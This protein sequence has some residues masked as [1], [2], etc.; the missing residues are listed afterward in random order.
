M[1]LPERQPEDL[2]QEVFL[3]YKEGDKH[4]KILRV[5]PER[6]IFLIGSSR[7]ADLRIGGEGIQGCHAALRFRKPYWYIC[8]LTGTDSLKING[9]AVVEAR[10]DEKAAVEI[11]EH[12]IELFSKERDTEL[13]KD[14]VNAEGRALHQVVIRL[15]GRVVETK[16]LKANESFEYDDGENLTVLPPPRDGKW[17][18]NEIGRRVVQQR[19]VG[20]QEILTNEALRLDQDL[21]KPFILSLVVFLFMFSALF[22]LSMGSQEAPPEVALDKKS[23]DIIFNAKAVK[24]KRVEAQKV[25]KTAKARAGGTSEQAQAAPGS[26]SMPE[27][28]MAPTTTGKPSVAL[29]SLRKA[30]LSNLVG[31]I[32]KRANK[33]GVLVAAQGVSADTPNAGRAFYST[34]TTTT[35]GGGSA[36]KEGPTYRLGGIATKGRAGGTGN[37][38]EGTALAGGNVGS[39][40]IVAMVDEETVIEGGLDRDAISEV[41]RRNL[42]QI[43]YCYERQLSSNPELYGKVLVKFTIGATG[44]VSEQRVDS[45]TLKSAMVE[46]CIMRRMAAWKF[47][48]PKGGT[49]VHVSYPFLFKAH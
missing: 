48:E 47:P 39:G 13:F 25:V 28:S 33:Q 21:R 19:L 1:G 15:R 12:R 38:K 41:I 42:G 16:I 34:G 36:A 26:T 22:M 10:L 20:E 11:G 17:V 9:Q 40:D 44:M 14:D 35:G 5:K 29:N 3:E 24:K 30:G 8:N 37:F 31:K 18:K 43:R 2:L 6:E 27:E 49:L 7:D 23:M 32:A 45:S 46:G 4:R